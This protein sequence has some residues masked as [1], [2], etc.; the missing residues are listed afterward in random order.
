MSCLFITEAADT[1]CAPP[2]GCWDLAAAFTKPS[3]TEMDLTDTPGQSL[4]VFS[5]VKLQ[6]SPQTPQIPT[7]SSETLVWPPP[8]AVMSHD[9]NKV[10]LL[11][12]SCGEEGGALA[13]AIYFTVEGKYRKCICCSIFSQLK[14]EKT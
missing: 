10:P 7:I 3:F 13:E 5:S 8:C 4:S 6:I 14:R 12:Q 2:P 11:G 9:G 1:E